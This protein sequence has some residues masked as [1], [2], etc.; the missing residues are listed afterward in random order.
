MEATEMTFSLGCEIVTVIN[1]GGMG[2]RYNTGA[3]DTI[4][5]APPFSREGKLDFWVADFRPRHANL[6]GKIILNLSG[7]VQVKSSPKCLAK[8]ATRN[9]MKTLAWNIKKYDFV[10]SYTD[11][12]GI[13]NQWEP[14][15][16]HY[17]LLQT[18]KPISHRNIPFHQEIPDP[19]KSDLLRQS[20]ANSNK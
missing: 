6:K 11:M 14:F 5:Q 20:Q 16:N 17:I 8:F 18:S 10:T 2:I 19:F 1:D 15:V 13:C 3:R 4:F 7:N 9:S 12:M